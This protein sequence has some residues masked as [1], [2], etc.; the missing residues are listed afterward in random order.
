MKIYGK[1]VD[2]KISRLKDAEN[3]E[4]ALRELETAEK[5]I[6][7]G[8]GTLKEVFEKGITMFKKFFL[9]ATGEDVL[10]ECSDFEEAK[11]ASR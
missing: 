11:E 6:G 5:K 4:M 7:E 8:S 2:F 10:G 9:K 3:F 1:E